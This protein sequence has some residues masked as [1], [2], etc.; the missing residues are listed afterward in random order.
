[1]LL[2]AVVLAAA[3]LATDAPALAVSVNS[4]R[5]EVVLRL[6]PFGLHA[7]PAGGGA[8]EMH[9]A[10]HYEMGQIRFSWPVA[11]WA[12][13]FRMAI[14]DGAGRP[15]SRE[16]LHHFNLIHL[17]RRQLLTALYERPLAVGRETDDAMLPRSTGVRLE[18]GAEMALESA[19]SNQTGNDYGDVILELTLS[20]LPANISPRPLDVRPLVMDVAYAAG[21]NNSF[22]VGPGRTVHRREFLMPIDGRLLGV[23]GHLHDYAESLDLVDVATGKVLIALRAAVDAEGKV[24]GVSRALYGVTGD[25]LKLMAGRR[26]RVE[27]VYANPTGRTLPQYGMGVM[28]G[29]FA[30]DDPERWPALDRTHPEFLADLAELDRKGWGKATAHRH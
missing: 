15:L 8:A 4:S 22:D 18:A 30:P 2:P 12:R 11:G 21:V 27:A 25:G 19:W 17:D 10:G 29:I 14:R 7:A 20:Y 6:G 16:L 23:G 13:G 24:T 28:V 9:H 3:A 26:Y 5:H 1:M